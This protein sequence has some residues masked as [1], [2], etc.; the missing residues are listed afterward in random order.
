MAVI[1][2]SAFASAPAETQVPVVSSSHPESEAAP[3]AA[4]PPS[5]E[6]QPPEDGTLV[7]VTSDEFALL[8]SLYQS[9]LRFLKASKNQAQAAK[10]LAAAQTAFDACQG[11]TSGA[12]EAFEV[13]LKSLPDELVK[14]RDPQAQAMIES[15]REMQA[16]SISSS[17]QALPEC[18]K[19]AIESSANYDLWRSLST[20]KIVDLGVPGLGKKKAELLVEK[21]PTIGDLEDSRVEAADS[22]VHWSKKLPKGFGVEVAD[23][24]YDAMAKLLRQIETAKECE[25]ELDVSAVQDNPSEPSL[26]VDPD[27]EPP[28]VSDIDADDELEYEDLDSEDDDDVNSEYHEVAVPFDEQKLVDRLKSADAQLRDEDDSDPPSN[29]SIE[30]TALEWVESLYNEI[31]EDTS[32]QKKLWGL[33]QAGKNSPEWEKGR[34]AQE[35]GFEIADCPYGKDREQAARDW[36]RGWIAASM[37]MDL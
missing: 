7:G 31:T 32:Q 11:E 3:I 19:Q 33:N 21:F 24:I 23:A 25:P 8:D 28:E 26:A 22:R 15:V 13:I 17:N 4:E 20:Q 12:K 27:P 9:Y 36:L 37:D 34:K 35:D 5:Q 16:V 1:D 14:I 6:S 18:A 2:M 30:I 10:D 29:G